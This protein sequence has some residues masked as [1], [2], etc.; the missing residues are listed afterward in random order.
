MRFVANEG[1]AGC[2]AWIEDENGRWLGEAESDTRQEAVEKLRDA[3]QWEIGEH[4]KHIEDLLAAQ[5]ALPSTQGLGMLAEER[6]MH[7]RN[8]QLLAENAI[9]REALR[10]LFE[11]CV[12]SGHGYTKEY[13]WPRALAAAR[14]ALDTPSSADPWINSVGG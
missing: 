6:A 9:L 3:I 4:G 14:A 10:L 12:L 7:E 8:E 5:E 11:E 1:P 13:G 2:L